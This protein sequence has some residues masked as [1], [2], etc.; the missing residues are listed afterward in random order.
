MN[1]QTLPSNHSSTHPTIH[2]SIHLST[3]QSIHLY[4]YSCTYPSIHSSIHSSIHQPIR[5]FNHSSVHPFIHPLVHLSLYTFI[6][7]SAHLRFLHPSIHSSIHPFSYPS[8]QSIQYLYSSIHI[9]I[10]SENVYLFINS[11][12]KPSNHLSIHY[13]NEHGI[14]WTQYNRDLVGLYI[15][16]YHEDAASERVVDISSFLEEP[17]SLQGYRSRPDHGCI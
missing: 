3:H 13:Q 4:I 5:P 7:S 1:L 11:Y 12:I 10:Y 16:I 17:R 8:I 2:P 15:I 14:A 9:L 6:H